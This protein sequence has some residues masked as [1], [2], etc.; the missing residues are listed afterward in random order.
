[1]FKIVVSDARVFKHA[2]DSIVN[3]IDEGQL[4]IGKDGIGLKAMDAS[5]IAMVCFFMPKDA[6]LEYDVPSTARVGVNFESLSKILGRTRGGE[7]L[8]ISQ[9]ENKLS[10]SF[11][12]EKKKR[13]FKLPMIDM[14]AG[15]QREPKI[16]HDAVVKMQG[17][18]FKEMLKDAVL[19]S[20]HIAFEAKEEGFYADVKGDGTDLK[21]EF[22]KGAG[23][24]SE[25]SVKAPSR[26]TFPLQ[27]LEDIVKAS[28]DLGEIVVHLKSN[29]PLKIEYS[30]EGAKVS[31]YLAPRIDSD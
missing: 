30:V 11:M 31:Y 6:F 24:I 4:E 28:P 17:G 23:E 20:S 25:I 9:D 12:A 27:Y 8:E 1:M 21:L 22:E 13:N 26:A 7:Q 19:V 2:I 29:A 10:L 5:Q 14:P 18:N 16:E 3:L 15:M